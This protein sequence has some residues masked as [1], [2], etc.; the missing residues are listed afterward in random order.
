MDTIVIIISAVIVLV[1][2]YK[3]INKKQ[4]P[5]M[6]NVDPQ[7]NTTDTVPQPS[8]EGSTDYDV[9]L[10]DRYDCATCTLLESNV[11]IALAKGTTPIYN[12][13]YQPTIGSGEQGMYVYKLISLSSGA[14]LICDNEHNAECGILCSVK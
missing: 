8:E 2:I 4:K 9:Y 12:E 13:F 5:S 14:G 7:P 11:L 1:F 10:S 6:P 3:I